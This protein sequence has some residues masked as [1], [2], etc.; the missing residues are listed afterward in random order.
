MQKA[1][2]RVALQIMW[3][4]RVSGTKSTWRCL[5]ISLKG[6]DPEKAWG[7]SSGWDEISGRSDKEP[8]VEWLERR[9]NWSRDGMYSK[10]ILRPPFL[11]WMF[12]DGYSWQSFLVSLTTVAAK[13]INSVHR[14]CDVR[15]EEASEHSKFRLFPICQSWYPKKSGVVFQK[16]DVTVAA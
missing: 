11:L 7:G 1:N 8:Q 16:A 14:T 2:C 10:Y 15:H 12:P 4:G 5:G 6:W 9:A 13:F 3:A